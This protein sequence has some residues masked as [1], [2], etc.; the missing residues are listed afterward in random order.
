M[1]PSNKPAATT[2]ACVFNYDLSKCP[3]GQ[4]VQALTEGGVAIYTAIT[5][6]LAAREMGIIAWYPVPIRDKEKEKEL[7][8]DY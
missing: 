4:K 3:K 5:S 1:T 8:Y 2:P 6:V 7:G